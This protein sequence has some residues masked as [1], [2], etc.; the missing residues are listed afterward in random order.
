MEVRRERLPDGFMTNEE[1]RKD[2][3]T[4]FQ[5]LKIAEYVN[6]CYLVFG[7]RI[8]TCMR[9]TSGESKPVE[10]ITLNMKMQLSINKFT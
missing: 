2:F 6:A 4:R 9:R 7:S 3:D 10:T 1:P 8:C 5:N